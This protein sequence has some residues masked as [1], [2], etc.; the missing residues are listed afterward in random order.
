MPAS[1]YTIPTKHLLAAI[2]AMRAHVAIDGRSTEI[3][4]ALAW[5]EERTLRG[6]T[7]KLVAD[8]PDPLAA[9]AKLSA[10]EPGTKW[11]GPL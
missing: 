9:L 5:A 7:L 11:A 8:Q 1:I 6:V 3:A 10:T 2:K 4:E